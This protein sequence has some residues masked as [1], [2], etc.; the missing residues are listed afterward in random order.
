[1][2]VYKKY[3]ILPVLEF[4]L[5]AIINHRIFLNLKIIFLFFTNEY[6]KFYSGLS[7]KVYF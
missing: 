2:I 4:L 5:N 1:M 7:L 6:L 3:S